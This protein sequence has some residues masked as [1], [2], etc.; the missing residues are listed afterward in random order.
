ME[1]PVI[2]VNKSIWLLVICIV[3]TILYSGAI[4]GEFVSDDTQY[5]VAN[6]YIT[7]LSWKG[8]LDIFSNSYILNYHPVTTLTW[9]LEYRFWHLNPMPYH[10]TNL[11]LHLVNII[12]VFI[13]FKKLSGNQNIALLV[14]ALFAIHPMHVEA[15]SWI[16]QRKDLLYTLFYLSSIIAYLNFLSTKSNRKYILSL[17]LFIFSLLSKPMAVTLPVLLLAVDYFKSGIHIKALVNK[18]PFLIF[19]TGFGILTLYTQRDIRFDMDFT[20]VFPWYERIFLV[21][22]S[23][24]LYLFEAILPVNLVL[25]HFYPQKS[26]GFFPFLVYL[27]PFILVAI[28]FLTFKLKALRKEV[29]FGWLF[30]LITI[31]VVLQIIPAGCAFISERYSYVPYLGLFFIAVSLYEKLRN[32]GNIN[33]ARYKN[34]LDLGLFTILI[35]LSIITYNRVKVWGTYD[36]LMNDLVEKEP[37]HSLSFSFRG[38]YLLNIRNNFPDALM[39]LNRAVQLDSLVADHYFS[40]GSIK[41]AMHDTIGASRDFDKAVL[42]N[43]SKHTYVQ[44]R[45]LL[46]LRLADFKRALNDLNTSIELDAANAEDHYT[47]GIIHYNLNDTLQAFQDVRKA[48]ALRPSYS[49]AYNQ[50]G[51]MYFNMKAYGQAIVN[52]TGAIRFKPDFAEAYF[53][54]AIIKTYIHDMSLCEDLRVASGLGF[55]QADKIL[56][57]NCK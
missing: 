43:P 4:G 42:L 12:L 14:S 1:L 32:Q 51:L 6:P 52:I 50:L 28:G 38:M 13:V 39:D 27:S 11:F 30:F 21:S 10:L 35:S 33:F 53:N 24:C 5:I 25:F 19:A 26:G 22:S 8:I 46:E 57:C 23:I 34:Y 49:A 17:L 20:P 48:I 18:I 29:V 55:Q 16:S 7:N 41:W 44:T 54:R 47:R 45:G 15:V 37:H 31:S 36:R 3:T 40:R 2:K 56:L 9:A